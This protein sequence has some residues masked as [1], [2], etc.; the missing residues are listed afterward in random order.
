MV[1]ADPQD[2]PACPRCG[3]GIGVP[4]NVDSDRIVITLTFRCPPCGHQWNEHRSDTSRRQVTSHV[5]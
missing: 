1:K 5:A 2:T 4:I 3:E